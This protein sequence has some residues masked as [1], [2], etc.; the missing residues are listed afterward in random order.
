VYVERLAEI[1]L[2]LVTTG[3]HPTE[4]RSFVGAY[5]AS[6]RYNV[7]EVMPASFGRESFSSENRSMGFGRWPGD[8]TQRY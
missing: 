2:Y 8:P 4:Y 3:S 7:H 1:S 5:E 6:L